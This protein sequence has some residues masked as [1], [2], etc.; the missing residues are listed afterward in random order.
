MAVG[1]RRTASSVTAQVI[2]YVVLYR[3]GGAPPVLLTLLMLFH[4]RLKW[5]IES[6][7]ELSGIHLIRRADWSERGL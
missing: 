1:Y 2:L 4:T 5:K 6:S 7:A 3:V